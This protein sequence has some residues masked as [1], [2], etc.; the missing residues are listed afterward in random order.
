[1]SNGIERG[2][3]VVA[4]MCGAIRPRFEIGGSREKRQIKPWPFA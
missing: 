4:H 2:V 3:V 1:M